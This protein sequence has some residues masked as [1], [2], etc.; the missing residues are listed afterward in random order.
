MSGRIREGA[1][2]FNSLRNVMTRSA[3][4]ILA[5]A[6]LGGCIPVRYDVDRL[7][8][9]TLIH[10]DP[11]V[12]AHFERVRELG[13]LIAELGPDVDP[14]EARRVAEA[15]TMLPLELATDYRLTSP[16]ITHNM[17]VNMG[18]RPRGLCT[19]FAEDMLR[20]LDA[21]Q[22]DT[23]DLYW[24]VAYPRR[25]FRLEHSSA[26]VTARGEP[27]ESG[28]V[29][30]AWRDSGELF[31]A[32]V[33]E[34]TRYAWQRLHNNITDP[35][36]DNSPVPPETLYDKSLRKNKKRDKPSSTSVPPDQEGHA[37]TG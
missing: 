32:P 24:A 20:R 1:A 13:D 34:D 30:D 28:V 3:L 12:A 22:L 15:A 2:V 10:S 14:T 4:I 31:F 23:L 6:F 9:A 27:F 33:A 7:T 5:I 37:S 18:M 16:P 26:V 29:L 25:R 8:D 36:P 19:H 17:L 21:M 11:E 35:P